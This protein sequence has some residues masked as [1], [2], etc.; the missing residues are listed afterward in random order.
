VS[1]N[2]TLCD[3]CNPTT[4]SSSTLGEISVGPVS[5]GHGAVINIGSGQAQKPYS[6]CPSAT[7]YRREGELR[8]TAGG[9]KFDSLAELDLPALESL[10]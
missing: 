10:Q 8:S 9:L 2:D 4:Q 6:V 7:L 3:F 1:H 5:T